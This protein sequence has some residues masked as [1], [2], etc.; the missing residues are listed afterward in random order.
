MHQI[1]VT[2]RKNYP[3]A[4]L[5]LTILLFISY[6]SYVGFNRHDNF[7]SRRL[8]LGN[9]E[10]TVWNVMRGNGF[11]LTDPMGNGTIS[12]L[13]VHA[14][15]LLI[16][17]APLYR[18]WQDPRMLIL[19]QAVVVAMGAIPVYWLAIRYIGNRST[20]LL[21]AVAYLLY[22]PIQRM[23][24]HDFHAVAL[25]MALLLF[26]HWFMEERRY[27][28]FIVT[29]F[30]AGLGKETVWMPVALMGLYIFFFQ[31]NRTVGAICTL[32]AGGIFYYLMWHAIPAVTYD[33]QHFA[34][35]YLSEFGEN[36]NA[37]IFSILANPFAVITTLLR[38][39][40]LFYYSQLL[41]PVGFLPVFASP[42]LLFAAPSMLINALS[43]NAHM[44]QID[45]QYTSEIIPFIFVAAIVGYANIRSIV[46]RYAIFGG[47]RVVRWLSLS[48]IGTAIYASYLWGELPL[49]RQDRFFYFIWALPETSVMKAIEERIPESA[50]VSVTNNI[51]SH[52]AKRKEL[53]NFPVNAMS[54][55]YA[56]VRL[57]DQYAWPSGN[58]QRET[59]DAL[60]GSSDHTLIAHDGEFY[61]FIKK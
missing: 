22:P 19:I 56:V 13:A 28:L 3:F 18:L 47:T 15:F 48:V 31:K 14:D 16:V 4:L 58:T 52:F 34:L 6:F 35:Q 45:Y 53:Y 26:A 9:M 2:I 49:T 11:V 50:S 38:P 30:F 23:V 24:L 36:Q 8:D 44:R 33:K 39:D 57:G 43:S 46:L 40:R 55:D 10:Q 61:A 54:S 21:F 51:G 25:S 5:W 37:I 7:H 41:F 60:L 29:A 1:L 59:V 42:Y 17:I 12:R 27:G 20:A 32:V